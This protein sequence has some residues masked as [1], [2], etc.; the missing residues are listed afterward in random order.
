MNMKEKFTCKICKEIYTNPITLNC[1]GENICKKHIEKIMSSNKF[2][3]LLCKEE[4]YHQKLIVN[5]FMENLIAHDLHKY[6]IDPKYQETFNNL[7]KEVQTLE[8]ILKNPEHAIDEEIKKLKRQVDLERVKLKSQ[9]DERAN[10]LIQQLESFSNRLKEEYKTNVDL[11]HY[12]SLVESS[13]K[14][15]EDYE[16]FL[17]LFSSK[18]QEREEKRMQN[19]KKLKNLKSKIRKLKDLLFSNFSISYKPFKGN[20]ED[21]YGKI[22]AEVSKRKI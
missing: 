18:N 4:N 5:E 16:H 14:Q 3:C 20:I 21:L 17:K 10:D 6:E 12:N 8:A 15:L 22:I 13:R 1:C 2:T 9:I 7:E 11:E 19:E